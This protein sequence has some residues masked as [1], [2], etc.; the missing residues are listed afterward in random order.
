MD[1]RNSSADPDGVIRFD[2][3]EAVPWVNG[4]GSTRV[5]A[6]DA[7]ANDGEWTYRVSVADLTGAQ[8]FSPFPGVH[9]H[10]TFLGPG[11]LEISVNDV[12]TTLQPCEEITFEGEDAVRS[13]PSA[14]AARDLNV[15][16][17]RGRADVLCTQVSGRT[18]VTPA[19][20]ARAEL[21]IALEPGEVERTALA[22]LDASWLVTGRPSAVRGR[23]LLVEIG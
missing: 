23:A 10:L 8:P 11:T 17:R 18:V 4:G 7:A 13:E 16:S 1:G 14:H 6:E 5:I 21:W 2:A 22:M 9:R 15:M 12:V 19:S 3:L 20:T